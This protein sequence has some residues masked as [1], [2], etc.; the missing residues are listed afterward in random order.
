MMTTTTTKSL[1]EMTDEELATLSKR[2]KNVCINTPYGTPESS[3]ACLQRQAVNDER[4]RRWEAR[5]AN[6][7]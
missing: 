1:T 6:L 3:A 5:E 4:N 2:L 7:G